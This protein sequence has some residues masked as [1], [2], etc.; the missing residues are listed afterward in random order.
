MSLHKGSLPSRQ[1]LICWG[2]SHGAPSDDSGHKMVPLGMVPLAES[3]ADSCTPTE[4]TDGS[5]GPRPLVVSLRH[6][7]IS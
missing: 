7:T 2:L 3:T 6:S 4:M 5:N 1:W